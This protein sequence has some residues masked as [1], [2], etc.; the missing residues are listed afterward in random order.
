MRLR[1]M[2]QNS[3]FLDD[4]DHEAIKVE[5]TPT[6][7]TAFLVMALHQKLP[8]PS[9]KGYVNNISLCQAYFLKLKFPWLK[10]SKFFVCSIIKTVVPTLLSIYRTTCG[11]LFRKQCIYSSTAIQTVQ[12]Q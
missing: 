5:P 3:F 6:I 2:D 11:A 10:F 4:I 12:V 7:K 9:F 1:G 8:R